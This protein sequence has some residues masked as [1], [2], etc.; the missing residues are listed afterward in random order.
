MRILIIDDATKK[1]IKRV[2]D[3]AEA[4]PY[5]LDDLFDI[6]NKQKKCAGDSKDYTAYIPVG[7]KMVFSIEH[8]PK[9]AVRH[10]SVSVDKKGKMPNPEAVKEIMK[11]V[12]FFNQL[13]NCLVDF[14]EF[15]PGYHA[16]NVIEYKK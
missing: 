2:V 6:K 3:F 8:Q 15:S 10:L 13:E 12:G 1:E 14:E 16:V 7:Y 4:N 5:S 9:G 11:E